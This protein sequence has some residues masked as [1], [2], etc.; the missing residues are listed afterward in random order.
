MR[1]QSKYEW[2]KWFAWRPVYAFDNTYRKH[3]VWLGVVERRYR[4]A[5]WGEVLGMKYR[6]VGHEEVS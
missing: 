2:H 4:T 1:L 5:P 6:L 3:R